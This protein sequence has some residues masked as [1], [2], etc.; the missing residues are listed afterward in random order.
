MPA[1]A[2]ERSARNDPLHIFMLRYITFQ[3][4]AKVG[5]DVLRLSPPKYL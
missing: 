4:H 3:Y 2:L 1:E 5:R